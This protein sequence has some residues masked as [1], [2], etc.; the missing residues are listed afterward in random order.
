MEEAFLMDGKDIVVWE[1]LCTF[2]VVNM[3]NA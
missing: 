2:A 1:T 3:E